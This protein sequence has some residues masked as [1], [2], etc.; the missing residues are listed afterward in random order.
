MSVVNSTSIRFLLDASA[1]LALIFDEPGAEV[2]SGILSDSAIGAVNYSEVL[3]KLIRRGAAP[4]EA[5]EYLSG[6]TVE[7]VPFDREL[8]LQGADLAPFAWTHGLSFG[9]RACLALARRYNVPAVT[10][11]SDWDIPGF[12]VQVR[13]I[14]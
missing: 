8:A 14:R 3:T 4:D 2:V 6:L 10:A 12:P 7:V 5:A 13:L 11:E 1:L 9:D